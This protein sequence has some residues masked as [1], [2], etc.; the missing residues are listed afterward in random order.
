[1]VVGIVEIS[2]EGCFSLLGRQE[3]ERAKGTVHLVKLS[4]AWPCLLTSYS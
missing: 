1:M 3:A 4:Q 2:G